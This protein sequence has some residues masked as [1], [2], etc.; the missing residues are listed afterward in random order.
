ME[1]DELLHTGRLVPIYPLTAGLQNRTIR[2]VMQE[3]LERFVTR[4]PDPL[5]EEMRE[6]LGLA[7]IADAVAQMHY[8]TD[9]ASLEARAAPPRV[10]RAAAD[11]AH[12]AAPPPPL[13]EVRARRAGADVGAA[14]RRAFKE[15][16][17][18]TLTGAQERVLFDVLSD[19]RKPVPMSPPG[20]GRRRQRQDGHRRRPRS[21]PRSRTGGRA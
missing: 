12:D 21:S 6:R 4:L 18:F 15:S 13:P 2:R 3:A 10:R 7:P 19:L 20:A 16:L 8:P 11:P 5:P 1:S 17:P 9:K 14:S